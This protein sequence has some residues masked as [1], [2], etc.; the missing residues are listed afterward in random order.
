MLMLYFGNLEEPLFYYL[1]ILIVLEDTL[2]RENRFV[3]V[4]K[5]VTVIR[6]MFV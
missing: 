4:T 5:I 3:L 6:D 1:D 2:F